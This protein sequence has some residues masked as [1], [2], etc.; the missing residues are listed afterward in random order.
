MTK[1]TGADVSPAVTV[2]NA[3]FA[4]T[5]GLPVLSSLSLSISTGRVTAILGPNGVGKTTLLNMILGWIRPSEGAVL[6]FGQSLTSMSRRDAGRTVSIVPQDEHLA[7]EYSLLDY[8]LLG[9]SPHLNALALPGQQDIAMADRCLKRV[10]MYERRFDPV[11]DIS[12]GEKQLVLLARSLCQEPRLLLLDEPSAHL[13]IA[14]KRRLVNLIQDLRNTGV[15]VVL[16]THDPDFAAVTSDEIVLLSDGNLLA[17][18][19]PSEVMTSAL[20][21]AAF[22][23]PLQVDWQNNHP[24]IIW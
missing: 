15:T 3:S 1:N 12:G 14:N 21:S 17:Q 13:D 18:G 8:V 4:Y 19:A 7:F 6:L 9:R 23:I 5:D 24:H 11:T 16:T 22:R 10:G 2:Q 20:L